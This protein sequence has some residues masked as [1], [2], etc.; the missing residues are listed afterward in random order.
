MGA[1]STFKSDHCVE[2]YKKMAAGLSD[3]EVMAMWGISR[4]TFYRWLKEHPELKEAHEAGKVAFDAIH[5][6]LGRQGML[7]QTDIDYQFW[8]DL[9]KYRHGWAEKPS[10]ATTNTQINIDTMNVLNEQTNEELLIYIKSQMEKN[11]ELLN[12]IEHE[13]E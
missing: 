2:I 1:I 3:T 6:D 8:R 11:P 12:I 10:A 4:G 13:S 5:E 7:K 9:G